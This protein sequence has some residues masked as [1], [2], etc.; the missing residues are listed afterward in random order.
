MDKAW[1]QLPAVSLQWHQKLR[2]DTSKHLFELPFIIR[3]G[4]VDFKFATQK[5]LEEPSEECR[6]ATIPVY[7]LRYL[8]MTI[9]DMKAKLSSWGNTFPVNLSNVS[10]EQKWIRQTGPSQRIRKGRSV[11]RDP[12]T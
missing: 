6:P 8:P 7:N 4:A 2:Y 1:F 9:G 3:P 11:S 12:L 10:A 5:A